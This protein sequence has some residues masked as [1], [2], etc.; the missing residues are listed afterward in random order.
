MIK[1]LSEKQKNILVCI[2]TVIIIPIV[3]ASIMH[4]FGFNFF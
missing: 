1:K 4:Y 3:V 2:A